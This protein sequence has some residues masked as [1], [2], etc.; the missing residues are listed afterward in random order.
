MTAPLAGKESFPFG[1]ESKKKKDRKGGGDKAAFG[2]RHSQSDL[3]KGS[4]AGRT[5][6]KPLMREQSSDRSGGIQSEP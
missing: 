4:V 3:Q 2:E 6:T 1:R 5:K